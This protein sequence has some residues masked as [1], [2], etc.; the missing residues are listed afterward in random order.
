[1]HRFDRGPFGK[2]DDNQQAVLGRAESA[3]STAP[4]Q[5]SRD[6]APAADE[7]TAAVEGTVGDGDVA[8]AEAVVIEPDT[9]GGRIT[10]GEA[11]IAAAAIVRDDPADAG[12]DRRSDADSV[13]H[14]IAVVSPG[15]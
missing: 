11:A 3:T 10:L 8:P 12:V 5:T 13:A 1:M 2:S 6:A 14:R 9:P 4:A 7:L 15:G